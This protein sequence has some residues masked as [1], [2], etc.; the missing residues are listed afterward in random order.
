MAKRTKRS[1]ADRWWGFTFCVDGHVSIS[2]AM[3]LLR[4]SDSTIYRMRK[5]KKLRLGKK[6]GQRETVVCKRSL[7]MA[8]KPIEH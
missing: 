5:R 8:M 2:D 4:V 7:E 1:E 3:E 6:P